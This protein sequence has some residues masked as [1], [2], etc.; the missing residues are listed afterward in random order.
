M[1]EERYPKYKLGDHIRYKY[2]GRNETEFICPCCNG[3]K[4]VFSKVTGDTYDCR[5]CYGKGYCV[6]TTYEERITDAFVTGIYFSTTGYPKYDFWDP[7]DMY[8]EL[9]HNR[10]YEE[11]ILGLADD[12]KR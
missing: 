12:E 11:Y 7:K 3:T 5:Q 2:T 1:Y 4:K 8:E 10:I 6:E 9:P